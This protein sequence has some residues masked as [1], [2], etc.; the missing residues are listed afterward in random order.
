RL[1]RRAR[2]SPDLYFNDP[3]AVVPPPVPEPPDDAE[4]DSESATPDFLERET[5]ILDGELVVRPNF[6]TQAAPTPKSL[7]FHW[8]FW[9]FLA[10]ALIGFALSQ[11]VSAF[12]VAFLVLSVAVCAG[13]AV[14][15]VCADSFDVAQAEEIAR[16]NREHAEHNRRVF[17]RVQQIFAFREEKMRDVQQKLQT[18][19]SEINE[20]VKARRQ[21]LNEEFTKNV[22]SCIEN[23]RR[24]RQE[25]EEQRQKLSE[26]F[27]TARRTLLDFERR[28][29]EESR[30]R[31][32]KFI[33]RAEEI[34]KRLN[35]REIEQEQRDRK[36]RVIA[37]EIASHYLTLVRADV[38]KKLNPNNYATCKERLTVA[39][40]SCYVL[41]LCSA[42]ERENALTSLKS[43]YE[44]RVRAAEERELQTLIKRQIREE[45]RTRR[46]LKE[47]EERARREKEAVE[48]KL[49]EERKQIALIEKRIREARADERA[50][51][52]FEL[53]QNRVRCQITEEL[54]RQSRDELERRQRA[55]SQAEPTKA[56]HVY[57]LSNKGSFGPGVYKI[58]MTRR[59]D[60]RVRV[61]E[62]SSA[63][64]PFTFDVHM[65]HPSENAPALEHELHQALSR[66]RVNK[67][68]PKKE[69][70]KVPLE[71]LVQEV[72]RICGDDVVF[73]EAEMEEYRETL[74]LA[75]SEEDAQ[76]VAEVCETV[77]RELY[78]DY[79]QQEFDFELYEDD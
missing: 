36:Y 67:A 23:E 6:I 19:R 3:T 2:F 68:K 26:E 32:Q 8:K 31:Y 27:A 69:F 17:E 61:A 12:W 5:S 15:F 10:T 57:I 20:E 21:K 55:T 77:R 78:R 53:E 33:E 63:S 11:N 9:A 25:K 56:G 50:R 72:K 64:V 74:R 14:Y 51:M 59:L 49:A 79:V 37:E 28:L 45:E 40:E 52:Q 4:D 76:F 13:I 22:L 73:V 43:E 29:R 42:Q 60:P 48:K 7:N 24:L 41:G 65:L 46:R 30:T 38:A 58:G 39:Y 71:T 16:R 18:F 54:Y 35:Q 75:A 70:F 66:Y 34:E 62:L 44:T 1:G 47:A